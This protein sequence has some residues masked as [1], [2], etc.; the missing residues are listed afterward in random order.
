MSVYST[1]P[2]RAF[3]TRAHG[4]YEVIVTDTFIHDGILMAR[5]E[6][7]DDRHLRHIPVYEVRAADIEVESEPIGGV[8]TTPDYWDCGCDRDYV[9]SKS[10]GSCPACGAVSAEQPDSR[11]SE[12]LTILKF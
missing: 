11:L 4:R 10:V 3:V 2:A 5:V 1:P 9:H 6:F 12:V 8:T 7:L